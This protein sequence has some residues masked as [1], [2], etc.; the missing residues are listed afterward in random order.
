MGWGDAPVCKHCGRMIRFVMTPKGKWLPCDSFTEP[1]VPN[2][3]GTFY[4][5][6]DGTPFRGRRT[7]KDDPDAIRALVPHFVTCPK[8]NP[9]K[10]TE[11]KNAAEIIAAAKAREEAKRAEERRK[12]EEKA[13]EAARQKEWTERQCSFF[14]K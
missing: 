4:Y 7:D 13:A 12:A 5:E 9:P 2:G 10:K 1:V 14:D 8:L 3:A 6:E 11:A